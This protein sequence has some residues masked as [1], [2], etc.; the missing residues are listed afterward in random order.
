MTHCTFESL[1]ADAAV[2]SQ[3]TFGSDASRGPIGPLKHLEKEAREAQAAPDDVTEFAD[4][5]LL[6]LDAAR[7]AG[8]DARALLAATDAKL[9]V[10]KSRVWS[11]PT[12]D[13]SPI[14]HCRDLT[15]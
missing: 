4:C 8:F 12:D 15:L 6:V 10:N 1:A 2:W 13:D 7:R 9:Q 3:E 11:K 5:L 14:E